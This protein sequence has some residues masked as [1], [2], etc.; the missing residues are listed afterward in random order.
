MTH[1]FWHKDSAN[2]P[3]PEALVDKT[4]FHPKTSGLY[5]VLGVVFDAERSRWMVRYRPS[6]QQK[7]PDQVEYV[8][9][10]EDFKR[11][12]ANGLP[13]FVEVKK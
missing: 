13:R 6:V 1:K 10:L 12:E 3:A 7:D 11:I 2:L 9:L 5:C 8:H 4:F